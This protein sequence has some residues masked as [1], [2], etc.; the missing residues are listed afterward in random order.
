MDHNCK[1]IWCNSYIKQNFAPIGQSLL[2]VQDQNSCPLDHWPGGGGST[3]GSVW[4]S[5]AVCVYSQFVLCDLCFKAWQDSLI[6]LYLQYFD[7]YHTIELEG[8]SPVMLQRP[9]GLTGAFVYH[10]P[11]AGLSFLYVVWHPIWLLWK[12]IMLKLW[13]LKYSSII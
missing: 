9:L 6:I 13:K 12:T 8:G 3:T 7:I 4:S 5:V 11:Y 10:V 2:P 1:C